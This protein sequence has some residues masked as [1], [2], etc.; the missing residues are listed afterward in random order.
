VFVRCR[1]RT[2][3][4]Y[5]GARRVGRPQLKRDPLGC[6][7]TQMATL[8][9]I[10]LAVLLACTS[11]E[12]PR[13]AIGADTTARKAATDTSDTTVDLAGFY[14]LTGPVPSWASDIDVVD[15]TG[16]NVTSVPLDTTILSNTR[17][18]PGFIRLKWDTA[19]PP[20][21]DFHLTKIVLKGHHFTFV[22]AA[23]GS[24]AYEFDGRFRR[25]SRLATQDVEGVVLSGRLRKLRGGNVVAEGD[26]QFRYFNGE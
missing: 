1:A 6:A 19:G 16:L 4:Q 18:S 14:F 9:V 5:Y 20:P 26:V 22:T 24:V 15:L 13:A 17:S 11:G 10:L 3:V 23:V 21:K 7:P 12:R 8:L 2:V 25:L